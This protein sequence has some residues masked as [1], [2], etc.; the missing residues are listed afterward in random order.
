MENP[1]PFQHEVPTTEDLNNLLSNLLEGKNGH[2][3]YIWGGQQRRHLRVDG[4]REGHAAKR[5]I[6]WIS[7]R[8]FPEG[9]GI[10]STCG[11][12]KCIKLEHLALHWPNVPYGPDLPAKPAETPLKPAKKEKEAPPLD[13]YWNSGD[14]SKCITSKAYYPSKAKAN[15]A[16]KRL[17]LIRPEGIKA[18]KL[19]T[20]DCPYCF[21][22]HLTKIPQKAYSSV[23]RGSSRN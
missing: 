13:S 2:I 15:A 5:I 9:S 22:H 20:Y 19:F 11:E 21:G 3:Y 14:R 17:N 23:K 12:A 10:A 7:G 8:K 18:R 1:W 6:W 16:A 4:H